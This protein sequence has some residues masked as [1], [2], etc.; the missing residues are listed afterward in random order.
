[1][2]N[3]TFILLFFAVAINMY[4]QHW[5]VYNTENTVLTSTTFSEIVVDD[6]NVTWIGTGDGLAK[7]ENGEL[8]LYNSSNSI[9][10]TQQVTDLF[11]DKSNLIWILYGDRIYRGRNGNF[12]LYKSDLGGKKIVVDSKGNIYL[13]NKYSLLRLKDKVILDTLHT[14]SENQRDY[15]DHLII[16]HNDN[17]WFHY[18]LGYEGLINIVMNKNQGD[19][20]DKYI[21]NGLSLVIDI[22]IDSSNNLWVSGSRFLTL[23]KPK[24]EKWIDMLDSFEIERDPIKHF[25]SITFDAN[26]NL[27]LVNSHFLNPPAELRIFD[28]GS[29]KLYTFDSLY[30]KDKFMESQRNISVD[31]NGNILIDAFEYGLFRFVNNTTSVNESTDNGIN[32]FPNPAQNKLHINTGNKIVQ[33]ISISDILGNGLIDIDYNH[34]NSNTL[35]IS[36]L[37]TGTYFINVMFDDGS[38]TIKKFVKE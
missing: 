5:E 22:G 2:R 38:S 34:N 31:K 15:I 17:L 1:M 36:T 11:L 18:S 12:E 25:N 35:D 19:S 23:K 4:S 33:S 8:S 24:E 6:N 28:E 10:P 29:Y 16:D 14:A 21:H 3:L 27:I 13:A 32:I 7:I 20:Y 37:A 30:K 26:N 9:L